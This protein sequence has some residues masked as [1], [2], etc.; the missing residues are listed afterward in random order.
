MISYAPLEEEAVRPIKPVKMQKSTTYN[1]KNISENTECNYLVMF[2][3]TGVV[4]L[5][6][7]DQ[8]KA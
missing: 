6:I 2:F 5:A 3:I 4:L 7:T 8:M 1:H